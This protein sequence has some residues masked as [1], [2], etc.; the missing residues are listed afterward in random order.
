[1]E[2]FGH[3]K[4]QLE[5]LPVTDFMEEF[6][7]EEGGL[8]YSDEIDE[9]I[10]SIALRR[11]SKATVPAIEASI[12]QI[13]NLESVATQ[14]TLEMNLRIGAVDQICALYLA[15]MKD[16]NGFAHALQIKPYQV[17]QY[18]QS[19][20]ASLLKQL[21][22]SWPETTTLTRQILIFETKILD[23]LTCYN[24]FSLND[25]LRVSL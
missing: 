13:S 7:N 20:V 12:E 24:I 15:F 19:V 6:L 16:E 18:W 5:Q 1:M 25:E 2:V 3:A 10:K 11:K 4:L 14:K 9:A 8:V 22:L 23:L 17:R 21:E